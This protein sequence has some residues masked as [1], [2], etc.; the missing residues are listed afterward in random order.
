V[1]KHKHRRSLSAND[2]ERDRRGDPDN[3]EEDITSRSFGGQVGAGYS[4]PVTNF[5]SLSPY[6]TFVGSFRAK[7]KLGDEEITSA[8][9]TLIQFGLGLDFH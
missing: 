1:A 3:E 9:L 7:L 8:S 5:L 4:I 6:F 2:L